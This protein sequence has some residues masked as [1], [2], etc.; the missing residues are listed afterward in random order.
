MSSNIKVWWKATRPF[1]FTVSV[2]PPILG[3]LIAVSE[4]TGISFSWFN[5]ALTLLGCMIAHAGA[6]MLSDYYDHKNRVDRDGTYGSSGVLVAAELS[7]KQ[8]MWGGWI[9]LI[10]AGLIGLYFILTIPNG[11]LILW[12]LIIGGVFAVFY[13]AGPFPFKYNALGDIAVFV[14]FGSAMVLGAYIVHAH[15]FSWTPVLYALPIAFLVDAI[16]HGNNL[17]DI[18]N[19]SEVAI[20]TMAIVLGNDRS[21]FMYFFLILSAYVLIV[22]FILFYHLSYFALLTFISLP[23]AIKLIKTVRNKEDLPEEEFAMID[24]LTAQFHS[25]FSALFIV[26]LLLDFFI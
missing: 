9:A 23:L 17:R 13:T 22:M 5:F 11:L 16:L 19:D 2:V 20:T 3:A 10:I 24:A 6:N 7:P 18:K 15:H 21:K 12:L 26:A 14:S 4:N 8:V 1:S 25:A